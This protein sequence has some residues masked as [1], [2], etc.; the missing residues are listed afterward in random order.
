[1]AVHNPHA[2]RGD[3]LVQEESIEY[4][5]LQLVQSRQATTNDLHQGGKTGSA[6]DAASPRF[7]PPIWNIGT[8]HPGLKAKGC[9]WESK[10]TVHEYIVYTYVNQPSPP[11]ELTSHNENAH[12]P[13]HHA[14]AEGLADPTKVTA[15]LAG[16][17]RRH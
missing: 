13:A 3:T 10:D 12:P 17:H 9:E 16:V 15:A 4:F 6:A 14:E 5:R 11:P 8:P 1:M 7:R 2:I